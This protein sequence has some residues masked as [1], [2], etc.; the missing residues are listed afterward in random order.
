[1]TTGRCSI[2][3]C[4]RDRPQTVRKA[5]DSVLRQAGGSEVIIV[6]D[7]AVP[8]LHDVGNSSQLRIVHTHGRGVGAARAA[9]LA[10][11]TGEF[12]AWCDDDDEWL[13]GHLESLVSALERSDAVDVVYGDAEWYAD[14]CSRPTYSLDFDA[15]LLKSFNYIDMS[16]VVLRRSAALTAGGFD[17]T[18]TAFEDWDL[19]LRMAAR[20]A[21]RRVP[22]TVTR[23]TW[24]AGRVADAPDWSMYDRVFSDQLGRAHGPIVPFDSKTWRDDRHELL[25]CSVLRAAEGYGS[26]ARSLLP[27]VASLGVDVTV[28]PEGNQAVDG[29]ERFFKRVT[30]WGRLAFYYDYRFLPSELPCE[31]VVVY[32][33]WE[34]TGIPA[35]H[36]A[37]LNKAARVVCVPCR[38]N[39]DA[40]RSAG[41]VV[42][43]E[44]LPHGVDRD[45]FPLIERTPTDV[46]TIGSFGHLSPR[47]GT[48]VLIRA[49]R[50]EFG[51][52]DD[53]RL[54]LKSTQDV[55]AYR[56]DDPRVEILTGNFGHAEL[57]RVL[58]MMNAFVLPSRGE[59]FGLCG[60]EAM[61]TG[62]PVIA[63]GWSGPVEYL[64]GAD[65]FALDYELVDAGGTESNAQVYTGAWAE[66]SYEHLRV[67]LRWLYEH[68]DEG[69]EMGRAAAAR[70]HRHWT[71][72]RSARQLVGVLDGA[73]LD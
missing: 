29:L 53:V 5:L 2:I 4:T 42:P 66:P 25:W 55:E 67:L 64:D 32:T 46:Y 24:V 73:A 23:R 37:E 7:G 17:S 70:V 54:L 16:N 43:I 72:E 41:L 6:D 48:D 33:M 39:A 63:T 20:G 56:V 61:A 27:A 28:V 19:W 36:I 50:D 69:A 35:P 40:Y 30:S 13:P 60:L 14:G 58:T 62:L 18:L 12:V 47:K 49:F 52:A 21:L 51:P 45:A 3:V 59:G 44:V 71:W 34:T 22:G 65:S 10:A 31:R 11:A 8:R 9:G 38:Q 26:V 1:M 15:Y 68:A 57:L